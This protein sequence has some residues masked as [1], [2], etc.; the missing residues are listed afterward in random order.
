MSTEIEETAANSNELD[1]SRERKKSMKQARLDDMINIRQDK[2]EGPPTKK[3]RMDS[4][5]HD[6]ATV[7]SKEDSVPSGKDAEARRLR[8]TY[9]TGVLERGNVY[10]FYRPKVEL[11]QA[12]SVEEVQR[13]FILLLPEGSGDG[14]LPEKFE[15]ATNGTASSEGPTRDKYYRLL[16][17]GKKRLPDPEGK[18]VFWGST[19][20]V[21]HDLKRLQGELGGNVYE[22]ATRGTRHQ[23]PA[24]LAGRGAYA[25]VNND[26]KAPSVRETHLG[27]HLSHPTPEDWGEVQAALNIHTAA[28]FQLQVKNPLAPTTGQASIGLPEEERVKYPE[29][30]M[31]EVFGKGGRRGVDEYGLRFACV[32]RKQMLNY[33][34]VELL[35]IPAGSG[36]QSVGD[37]LGQEQNEATEKASGKES[38][39]GVEQIFKELAMN[40]ET[41]PAEPLGGQWA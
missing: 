8:Q 10:F 25:I 19:S 13:F 17:V 28:S 12:H 16:V 35:F 9:Q 27:Y 32:E 2:Q 33:E 3:A 41:I 21:D 1:T 36:R 14:T 39:E 24:R 31:T 26:P 40:A 20:I 30:I 37:H 18:S 15:D 22:T 6:S 4:G 7:E 29:Q 23:G 34:G 38:R 5:Q 11:Q